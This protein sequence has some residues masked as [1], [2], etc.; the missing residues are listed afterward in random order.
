MELVPCLALLLA[1]TQALLAAADAKKLPFGARLGVKRVRAKAK[2]PAAPFL[3]DWRN[4]GD[5]AQPE[6]EEARQEKSLADSYLP[7][8]GP[9]APA[10]EPP[11]D[12]PPAP[13]T[14]SPIVPVPTPGPWTLV[15]TE[16]PP[17]PAPTPG[18]WVPIEG[19]PTPGP[20]TTAPPPGSADDPPLINPEVP[21][22][23]IDPVTPDTEAAAPPCSLVTE[24][25]YDTIEETSCRIVNASSCSPA[26]S[27]DTPTGDCY[28]TLAD[29][30]EDVTEV[31]LETMVHTKV[32]NHEEGPY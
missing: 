29:T 25:V 31:E 22:V 20:W 16:P 13:A 10:A 14:E 21:G 9:E 19:G 1:A 2:T 32:R 4:I 8:P 6:A 12:D 5:F 30:C 11:A 24:T 15:P 7:P 28:R 3:I 26:P 27:A 23:I 17:A 18:P